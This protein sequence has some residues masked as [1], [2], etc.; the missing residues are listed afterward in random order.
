[1]LCIVAIMML[2]CFI[3][4]DTNTSVQFLQHTDM[5]INLSM[6]HSIKKGIIDLQGVTEVFADFLVRL[7]A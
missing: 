4:M 6:H 1:M 7:S 5:Y 2:C 3:Y